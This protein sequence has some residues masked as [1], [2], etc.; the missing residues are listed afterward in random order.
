[1]KKSKKIKTAVIVA[2]AVTGVAGG[3]VAGVNYIRKNNS[4]SVEVLP[5]SALN[6]GNMSMS[7]DDSTSGTVVSNVSQNVRIPD[8]KVID[9]VYVK[10]GDKVKIGD[11]LLSYDTTLLE[12]DQELQ[13]ITVMEL[14]L[15]IKAAEA[16]LAKLQ[17]AK[18]GDAILDNLSSDGG[19]SLLDDAGDGSADDDEDSGDEEARLI[20]N[21]RELLA[22]QEDGTDTA[23]E[24]AETAAE[25]ETTAA[26]ESTENTATENTAETENTPDTS[27]QDTTSQPE[28][29]VIID[30]GENNSGEVLTPDQ[31]DQAGKDTQKSE[32][33]AETEESEQ[34]KAKKDQSLE[35]LFTNVRIK[36]V[37]ENGEDLLADAA[38]KEED[39]VQIEN[40]VKVIPHFKE[41][42]E[43]HFQSTDTYTMLVHGV[44]LKQQIE[45]KVYGTAQINGEDYP[46][47]GG[48]ILAQKSG[49]DDTA[50]LT[51]AFH[52]G[53]DQQHEIM[54]ELEDMY[55][56]L[57]L[58]PDEITGDS[59]I[60]RTG[61][62]SKD[63]VITVEKQE[64]ETE[65]PADIA[66]QELTDDTQ[67]INTGNEQEQVSE[68]ETE[69]E[70]ESETKS[71]PE[72]ETES[73]IV[74]QNNFALQKIHFQIEWNHG[75][76]AEENWPS[77]MKA[78]FYKKGVSSQED[79]D[80]S[81][82]LTQGS[83]A[84]SGKDS[85][86]DGTGTAIA[87]E[88]TTEPAVEDTTEAVTGD[89]ETETAASTETEEQTEEATSATE[90]I[91]DTDTVPSKETWNTIDLTVPE[92]VSISSE[93]VGTDKKQWAER[94][95]G[96]APNYSMEVEDVQPDSSDA[97]V[98]VKMKMTY[99]QPADSPLIK[100]NPI[101]ELTW[102]HGMN[103]LN[104]TGMRAYKGSGTAED[105][106]VFFVTDGVK[107][108]NTFVNWVLGF[109]AE[110]TKRISD[111]YY[112]RLEI[113][114]S[115]TITGAFIRSIDL[116]GTVLTDHGYG[117]GTYWIFSSDTGITKYEEDI[118]DDEPNIPDGPGG[119][120][121][122]NDGT[123]YTA[124]ELAQAIEDKKLEIQ[125]LKLDERQAKLKLKDYNKQ[126]DA[127]TVVSS[128]DGYIKSINGSGD[129]AYM[130][131]ESE[132]G[133]YVKT[134]VSELNLE[135]IAVDQII[136]CESYYTGE[137]FTATITEIDAFPSDDD[138]N[139]YWGSSGNVN[140]SN[141]PVLAVVDA[142]A[143]D[144]LSEYD[145]VSVTYPTTSTVSAG[146]IYL[147][148]AYIRSENG[149]SYVYA[150]D[151]NDKLKKQ[152]IRTGATVWGYVEVKQG[153]STDDQIAFPYGKAVK[154]GAAVKLASEYE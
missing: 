19:S 91:P 153:L 109:N 20:S 86:V 14:G 60:L 97:S 41:T 117:P 131:V 118:P 84:A 92:G 98:T 31:L 76:D 44:T 3:S 130:V 74:R 99:T 114:E 62:E 30:Q 151:E 63:A 154:E 47:I 88:A 122:D 9:Q 18:P 6:V 83:S 119:W 73:E 22:S 134:S 121:N 94:W 35:K 148:K 75:T 26:T 135:D 37:T 144:G 137:Q 12:L 46:E 101:A 57:E 108:T 32:D 143:E 65:A 67:Q 11:K 112:I 149:Q 138:S 111:G 103:T 95:S 125:K 123:G 72:T 77:S 69:E 15:E 126:M 52:D 71:E 110:G 127:S 85:G 132:N 29:E 96:Y 152:Y 21:S 17:N 78:Y 40:T 128:V 24:S 115:N 140:S 39:T 90:Q 59:L 107:I 116:D 45:G 104:E 150:A 68:E 1:M 50:Q 33:A 61:D 81:F 105:P 53:L 79:A 146:S 129:D 38:Q 4:K 23:A 139:S 106:Y 49:S 147:D 141:Y 16:D 142:D 102:Q 36:S 124:E 28:S 13:E 10:E 56:E 48:F 120:D 89:G 25:T 42:V 8:G 34:K 80:C 5:V 100:L 58:Q 27:A 70:T 7:S 2:A 51:I 145:D 113:R 64:E 87:E 43:E 136:K 66:Q 82:T 133:L 93:D 54:P 55:L